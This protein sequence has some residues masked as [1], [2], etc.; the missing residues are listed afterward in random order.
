M[1]NE[2]ELKWI[3][4]STQPQLSLENLGKVFRTF[5]DSGE[6]AAEAFINF[7]RKGNVTTATL[8]KIDEQGRTTTKTLQAMGDGWVQVAAKTDRAVEAF[9]RFNTAQEAARQVGTLGTL[10]GQSSDS[11]AATISARELVDQAGIKYRKYRAQAD[12]NI[13]GVQ[14]LQTAEINATKAELEAERISTRQKLDNR[15]NLRELNR[16]GHKEALQQNEQRTQASQIAAQHERDNTRNNASLERAQFAKTQQEIKAADFQR[17]IARKN[18]AEVAR[19][20]KSRQVADAIAD[21]KK[22]EDQL[23]E[24]KRQAATNARQAALNQNVQ[25]RKNRNLRVQA[26]REAAEGIKRVRI[27][28]MRANSMATKFSQT[29]SN[30]GRIVKVSLIHRAIFALTRGIAEGVKGAVELQKRIAEIRTISQ[31]QPIM[32]PGWIEGLRAISDTSG[33]DI[34]AVTEGAYQ[35]LSNQITQG[36][37]TFG[38]LQEA[39]KF[40]NVAVTTVDQSV[41]LLTASLNAFGRT[42]GSAGKTAAQLFKTIEL[43]R[44]RAD[45]MANSFGRIAVLAN[46]L[47]IANTELLASISTLTIQGMKYNEVATQLRGLMIS[48]IKPTKDMPKFLASMGVET[49]EAAIAIDGLWG[50]MSKLQDFTK[51]SASELAKLVPRIRGITGAAGLSGRG[52]R[53]YLE[54]WKEISSAQEDY[55]KAAEIILN[56]V[57]KRLEIGATQLK[58]FFRVDI[59][60]EMLMTLDKLPGGIDKVVA[61]LQGLVRVTVRGLVP[62]IAAALIGFKGLQAAF[63]ATGPIILL[64]LTIDMLWTKLRE[65]TEIIK[66]Q[67]KFWREYYAAQLT[68]TKEFSAAILEAHKDRVSQLTSQ[69]ISASAERVK[70]LSGRISES[71]AAEKK[72]TNAVVQ[73]FDVRKKAFD[74]MEAAQRNLISGKRQSS[75]AFLDEAKTARGERIDILVEG[76]GGGRGFMGQQRGFKRQ[77][78]YLQNA[79]KQIKVGSDAYFDIQRRIRDILKQRVDAAIQFAKTDKKGKSKSEI[80]EI[81]R[82]ERSINTLIN[83]R[84][85]FLI[86]LEKQSVAMA[87]QRA[88]EANVEE[89]RLIRFQALRQDFTLAFKTVKGVDTEKAAKAGDA[90]TLAQQTE[91]LKQLIKTQKAL[92]LDPSVTENAVRSLFKT[93]ENLFVKEVELT[94][95]QTGLNLEKDLNAAAEES[96]RRMN[97]VATTGAQLSSTF[98]GITADILLAKK[99]AF[100]RGLV[101]QKGARAA[102]RPPYRPIVE[103]GDQVLTAALRAF[104]EALET[105]G[106]LEKSRQALLEAS[107]NMLKIADPTFLQRMEGLRGQLERMNRILEQDKPFQILKGKSAVIDAVQTL[108]VAQKA[109]ENIDGLQSVSARMIDNAQIRSKAIEK[110]TTQLGEMVL[111]AQGG[112]GGGDTYQI[113]NIT[114]QGK[115]SAKSTADGL[116]DE[117]RQRKSRV[118]PR[119]VTP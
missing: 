47:G 76:R 75:D 104:R 93:M 81:E 101:L 111:Q 117:L 37:D 27:E 11:I 60:N 51:G 16:L 2:K 1:P 66:A 92:G 44:L 73:E 29:W 31:G 43:G 108:R 58:S 8:K 5:Q 85:R 23:D 10:A 57:G 39:A 18:A 95:Q 49:G 7:S 67:A 30:I 113:D 54:N 55:G 62:G 112:S 79:Q 13:A 6:K 48:L 118:R 32:V 91:N 14:E 52:L 103:E 70:A 40:A 71:I 33:Q 102:D 63:V 78:T 94:K 80:R 107:Q 84:L 38:F 72:I 115:G 9:Q 24:S 15:H 25:L 50:V 109:T 82:A 45:D 98:A 28:Q 96:V 59:A 65:G 12:A 77:L 41:N 42:S 69:V 116:V 56:N 100:G 3:L 99:E 64:G 21:Q 4:D 90:G 89:A 74:Q 46:Q 35:A 86:R 36:V 88:A 17:F 19:V 106:P 22:I 83:Q 53:Q 87:K 105:G 114:I 119:T 97:E 68:A 26:N 20:T 61:S 34:G 110:L